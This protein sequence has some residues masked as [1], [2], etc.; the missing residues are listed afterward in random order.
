[1]VAAPASGSGKTTLTCGLLRLLADEGLRP[2]ALKCGPDY[3][4]PQFHRRVAGVAAGNL[5]TYFTDGPTCAALLVRAAQGCDVAVL[6]GVMG[7]YDGV[8]GQG[9]RASSYDVA[10]ATSTPVVLVLGARGA[11]LTLAALIRG[12]ATFRPDANI[13]GVVLNGCAPALCDRL[14]PDLERETGVRV[15]GC[16]PRD[17]RFAIE[18]RHLGLVG[19]AEVSD[20]RERIGLLAATL[21]ETLNVEA[22]LRIAREAP[23]LDV[24][25]YASDPVAGAGAGSVL[26]P[27]SPLVEKA[28]REGCPPEDGRL[29]QAPPVAAAP[30]RP[31]IAVA[32]DEAFS[33]Y[34]DENLRM[35]R[36]LGA[37]LA[38][39]SPLADEGLPQGAGGLYLGGGYPELHAETLAANA[40]MRASVARAVR[41]AMAGGMPVL[42][43]CGGFMYLLRELVDDEGRAWPMAGALSGV[44]RNEG[45]LRHFGYVELESREPSLLGPV[46]TRVRAHEFH[47]WHADSEGDACE[48]RKPAPLEADAANSDSDSHAAIGARVSAPGMPPL[49]RGARADA[50]GVPASASGAGACGSTAAAGSAGSSA[51]ASRPASWPC[52]VARGNLLAG[53]PHIYFPAHSLLAENFVRAAVRAAEGAVVGDA[54]LGMGRP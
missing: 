5:D 47:Y 2:A 40:G 52:M 35:L 39:F 33:F 27:G 30:G 1:M 28:G 23:A 4:D 13:A 36:D 18:S 53:Y 19:P 42:A 45:R 20:L 12:I 11:S 38:F 49:A 6:E 44:A 41:D 34:Y 43:E 7:Y 48:A 14:R 17:E 21:R 37:E 31:L 24:E 54:P 25:P 9:T 15:L 16:L 8:M 29:P 3:I 51:K 32:R 46:G 10:R 26:S 50:T 22:L